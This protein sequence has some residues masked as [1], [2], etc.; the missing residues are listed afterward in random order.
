MYTPQDF[1][2]ADKEELLAFIKA[3]AF[4]QLI[5]LVDNHLF[6]SHIPFSLSADKQTLICHVAKRNPQ[7]ENIETQEVL[8]TFQGLHD[9]IS[10]S[11]Y[12]SGGVPTWNYQAVHVYGKPK[13]ITE[14]EKLKV[15]VE[16]LTDEYESAF[17][18]PW[19]PE[20]K[21]SLL[22]MIVGIQ[23][24][25]TEIQGKYK[26]SQNRPKKDQLKVIE[27]LEKKGSIKLSG[28]MKKKL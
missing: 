4:G 13:L 6:S 19:N 22:N 9:Y 27:E 20:Y 1:K 16:E 17:E 14:P 5:S 21:E 8:I 23:I 26:L 24:N 28:T 12:E 7:W 15:I 18:R 11:W 25:I 3:N 2:V 10:P